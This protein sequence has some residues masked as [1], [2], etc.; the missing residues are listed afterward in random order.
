MPRV[1]FTPNLRRHVDCPPSEVEGA[2]VREALEA[3]FADNPRARGYVLDDQGAVRK[4]V[5]VFVDG[6]VVQDRVGLSDA[7]APGA[8]IYIMQALS[9]G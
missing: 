6:D 7:V 8:E 4:H 9:G 3:A 1:T 5:M 2:T